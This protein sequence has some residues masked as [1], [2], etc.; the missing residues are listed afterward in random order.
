MATR[1]AGPPASENVP[2]TPKRKGSG[3]ADDSP[4]GSFMHSNPWRGLET[5]F[6]P[7]P[8]MDRQFLLPSPVCTS[9]P[10]TAYPPLQPFAALPEGESLHPAF[11]DGSPSGLPPPRL[12]SPV[13]APLPGPARSPGAG[14]ATPPCLSPE[15]GGGLP[16]SFFG[17]P[18]VTFQASPMQ[19]RPRG[20]SAPVP[21]ELFGAS[22]MLVPGRPVAMSWQAAP[23]R[24][25]WRRKAPNAAAQA[26][27]F[28][29]EVDEAVEE[30][31]Y[32]GLC[33]VLATDGSAP[34]HRAVGMG[35]LEAV[36][37]LL[38]HSDPNKPDRAGILPLAV[39]AGAFAASSPAQ[40][41][42]ESPPEEEAEET[43]ETSIRR[44]KTA[45]V[46]PC[47]G[48]PTGD[49]RALAVTR[50]LLEAGA[51]PSANVLVCAAQCGDPALA[52]LLLDHK[53]DPNSEVAGRTAL[54]HASLNCPD[55]MQILLDAGATPLPCAR[56]NAG[57][58]RRPRAATAPEALG[59]APPVDPP[60]LAVMSGA[61]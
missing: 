33:A 10:A 19:L 21:R 34:L 55:T 57:T 13:R 4:V 42:L 38:E 37:I 41:P 40:W 49:A 32:G 60:P 20:E 35:H 1:P 16:P 17:T 58:R 48:G 46:G 14:P 54:W 30:G 28:R 23:P 2:V 59:W 47:D 56:D 22:P 18:G 50:A 25:A 24:N 27:A 6:A 11:P 12:L 26:R 52:K 8:F 39:A 45:P 36:R 43:Q 53:A 61:A 3:S 5:P 44:A 7:S 9:Q 15:T 29:R 31:S 51:T